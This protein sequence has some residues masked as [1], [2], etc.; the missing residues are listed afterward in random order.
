MNEV[1]G[2]SR[3]KKRINKILKQLRKLIK[4]S[5]LL[6]IQ[7]S[8]L[9]KLQKKIGVGGV[10]VQL[11]GGE[12]ACGRVILV[13]RECIWNALVVL[14]VLPTYDN[15]GSLGSHPRRLVYLPGDCL[16]FACEG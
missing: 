5:K 16:P 2:T 8:H 6:R 1:Y 9:S 3:P 4:L 13:L 15:T 11:L 10:W 7:I 12:G 14:L